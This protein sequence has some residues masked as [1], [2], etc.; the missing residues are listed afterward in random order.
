MHAKTIVAL[1]GLAVVSVSAQPAAGPHGPPPQDGPGVWWPMLHIPLPPDFPPPP[2]PEDREGRGVWFEKAFGA[3]DQDGDGL[4][5]KEEMMAAIRARREARHARHD[6]GEGEGPPAD[7]DGGGE[8]EGFEGLSADH[9][10]LAGLPEPP[11]CGDD[12]RT[13]EL[14]VQEE[15][16]ACEGSESVGNLIF[17]TVCNAEPYNSEAISLPPDRAAACFDIEA[18]RGAGITFEIIEESTGNVV[19]NTIEG[20]DQF[21]RLVLTGGPSGTVYR[22]V[23]LSGDSP[24]ASITVRFIDHPTF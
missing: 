15:N 5:S 10:E 3:I 22:I 7:Y 16:K 11:P 8:G 9:P 24:D 13:S 20:P 14:G 6:G 1:L 21:K 23:L 17:R 2:P 4:I 18:I 12:L 19:F